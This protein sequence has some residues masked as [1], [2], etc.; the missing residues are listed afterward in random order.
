MKKI[1]KLLTIWLAVLLMPCMSVNLVGCDKT[2]ILPNGNYAI[3]F[4]INTFEYIDRD[5]RDTYGWV[6]DGDTAE[7]WTSSVCEYKAKI[8]KKDGQILFDGYKWRNLIDILLGDTEK[9]GYDRDYIVVY[10]ETAG[11]ITLTPKLPQENVEYVFD[12]ITFQKSKGLTLDDLSNYIP[13][14]QASIKVGDIKTVKDFEK[15]LLNNL[16]TYKLVVT[17]ENGYEYVYL[18]PK[19]HSITVQTDSLLLTK[20]EGEEYTQE[21]VSCWSTTNG[22]IWTYVTE[23]LSFYWDSTSTFSYRISFPM[24]DVTDY[25]TVVYNYKIK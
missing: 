19:Y 4:K 21:E 8:V 12:G 23:N 2:E 16:D 24:E 18:T 10:D 11:T 6:I 15:L 7:L 9:K 1:K 22:N 14:T 5:V 3:A 20:K 13:F 17:T 25:F